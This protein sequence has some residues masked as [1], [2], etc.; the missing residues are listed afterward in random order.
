MGDDRSSIGSL[1]VVDDDERILFAFRRALPQWGI[2]PY[3]ANGRAEALGIAREHHPDAGLVD[4]QLGTDSGLDLLRQLRSEDPRMVVVMITGYSSISSTVE[5]MRLG[6]HD[7]VPK[8]ASFVEIIRRFEASPTTVATHE[9]FTPSAD[10]ALWEHVTRVLAD[11]G[12][13]KSEAARR[14]RKPRSWLHR[15]LARKAPKD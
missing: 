7:V 3:V 11:C 15:F 6:A 1:L 4:L 13:N 12:G 8:P 5:A 2:V 14:L 10:R 9:I